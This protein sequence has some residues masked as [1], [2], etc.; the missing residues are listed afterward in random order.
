MFACIFVWIRQ[1][2]TID[3]NILF[4]K[5]IETSDDDDDYFKYIESRRLWPQ[6]LIKYEFRLLDRKPVDIIDD[7]F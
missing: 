2:K 7:S 3:T 5:V 4:G 1:R 6:N